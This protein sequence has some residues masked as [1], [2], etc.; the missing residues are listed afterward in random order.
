MEM[1]HRFIY[2]AHQ[3]EIPEGFEV[4]HTCNNRACCNPGHL[5]AMDGSEHAIHT[6]KARILRR[7]A[8]FVA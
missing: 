5:R 6:N 8:V 3:G 2:R 7:K 4:D 1:F